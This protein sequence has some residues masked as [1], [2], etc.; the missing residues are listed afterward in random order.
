MG[1]LIFVAVFLCLAYGIGWVMS[2]TRVMGPI[3]TK[4]QTQATWRRDYKHD[5]KLPKTEKKRKR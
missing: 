2:R 1:V 3:E 4:G 5:S